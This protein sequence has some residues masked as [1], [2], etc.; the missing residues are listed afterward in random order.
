M[1]IGSQEIREGLCH[2]VLVPFSPGVDAQFCGEKTNWTNPKDDDD[3]R[4]R[5]YNPFCPKHEQEEE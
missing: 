2:W 1:A 4:R 3:N 5:K